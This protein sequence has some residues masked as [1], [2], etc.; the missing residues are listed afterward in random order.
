[1]MFPS[2]NIPPWSMAWCGK[3]IGNATFPDFDLDATDLGGTLQWEP[4]NRDL[5]LG[6]ADE[7]FFSGFSLW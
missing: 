5:R 2:N 1:M 3:V 4:P 6:G 7:F